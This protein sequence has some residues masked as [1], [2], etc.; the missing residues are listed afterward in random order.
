MTTMTAQSTFRDRRLLDGFRASTGGT[1]WPWY[2]RSFR[3]RWS[4]S[5]ARSC[6]GSSD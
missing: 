6:S 1:S 5:P 4:D 3:G 2:P